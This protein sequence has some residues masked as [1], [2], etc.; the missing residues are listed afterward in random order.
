MPNLADNK[1]LS[2]LS[3][4]QREKRNLEDARKKTEW[5]YRTEKILNEHLEK[6]KYISTQLEILE[7][8]KEQE[9]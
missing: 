3:L 4:A 1:K 9:E 2:L 5:L 7:K 8:R 6:T